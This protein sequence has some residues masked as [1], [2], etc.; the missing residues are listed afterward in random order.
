VNSLRNERDFPLQKTVTPNWRPYVILVIGVIAVSTSSLFIR[1]AQN[2]A[3]PSLVIA[4]VRLTIAAL[5]LTPLALTRE[6]ANLHTLRGDVLTRALLSGALLGLHFATWISSLAYTSVVSSVVLVTTSPLWVALATPFVLREKIGRLTIL[7]ILL[8]MV[9]SIIVSVAGDAGTALVQGAPMLGNALA[10][11]GAIAVAGYFLIGRQLRAS[12]TTTL[13]VWVTYSTA[14]VTL[15]ILMFV[16]GNTPF[17]LT[18][19]AWIWLVLLA[20]VPQLIGHTSYN[21]ALGFLSAAYV[22]VTVLGEPVVSTILAA[23][24][25]RETPLPVQLLG[26][27]FI[28]A[29]LILSTREEL[30]KGAEKRKNKNKLKVDQTVLDL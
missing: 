9:G 6:R 23:L 16:S 26:G 22:S 29:A 13:Y 1:F 17:G 3:A 11:A 21:Y 24:F 15:V 12:L 5:I 27:V 7:A 30:M 20:L 2:A 28:F 25:L 19:D 8:G 14:A 10:V 4:A 18:S